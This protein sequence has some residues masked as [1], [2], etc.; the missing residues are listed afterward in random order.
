[1][2]AEVHTPRHGHVA[3]AEVAKQGR[4]DASGRESRGRLHLAAS[5]G[6]PNEYLDA[7]PFAHLGR[8]ETLTSEANQ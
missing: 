4:A 5:G 6:I 7:S 2:A 3:D 8:G 1:M